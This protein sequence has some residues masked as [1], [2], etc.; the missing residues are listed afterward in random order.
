[1]SHVALPSEPTM[2]LVV[3]ARAERN[4]HP[5]RRRDLSSS[6]E[7]STASPGDPQ[8]W[9]DAFAECVRQRTNAVG[10][11][12]ALNTGTELR[13]SGT[14]GNAP[15]KGTIVSVENTLVGECIRTGQIICRDES[16]NRK[17]SFLLAPIRG[18]NG[19][20]GVFVL[21]WRTP[22]GISDADTETAALATGM[23][24]AMLDAT[25][26]RIDDSP[27]DPRPIE[28]SEQGSMGK[29]LYGLPCSNCGAYL[30]SDEP[31]CPVCKTNSA[32]RIVSS[33]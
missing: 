28:K 9:I 33:Q 6:V 32:D 15:A 26:G 10:A 18:R 11:A 16:A 20:M 5:D 30:Y 8:S 21:F 2:R 7:G 29:R 19:V 23:I 27:D 25:S 14:A 12:V 1:M 3:L 22:V 31:S 13:C 4:Q 24:A 17:T